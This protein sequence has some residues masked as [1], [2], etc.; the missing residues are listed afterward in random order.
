MADD[1]WDALTTLMKYGALVAQALMLLYN[2]ST[3]IPTLIQGLGALT[4]CNTIWLV[5]FL[6]SEIPKIQDLNNNTKT[7]IWW[8]SHAMHQ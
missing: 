8:D 4:L 1:G 3:K 7:N 2:T 6:V 5:M